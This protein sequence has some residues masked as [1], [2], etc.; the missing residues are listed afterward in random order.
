VRQSFNTQPS[1]NL[2][3]RQFAA[4]PILKNEVER[5]LAVVV[6]FQLRLYSAEPHQL[7]HLYKRNT[8]E[9]DCRRAAKSRSCTRKQL[10]R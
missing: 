9:Y 7:Q 2:A 8:R 3:T 1:E 5:H 10:W 6:F 4:K